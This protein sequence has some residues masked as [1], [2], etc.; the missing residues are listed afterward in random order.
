MGETP[1]HNA[2]RRPH[3]DASTRCWTKRAPTGRQRNSG[4][5]GTKGKSPADL[6]KDNKHPMIVA[7]CDPAF[8]KAE[9]EKLR[10]AFEEATTVHVLST[11]F[12][13]PSEEVVAA[14]Y[15][16]NG[17]KKTKLNKETDWEEVE[18]DTDDEEGKYPG[19]TDPKMAASTT[20]LFLEEGKTEHM[21][22]T[23]PSSPWSPARAWSSTRI[24]P[25]RT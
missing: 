17:I 5:D 10:K 4:A 13:E 12:N 3:R 1:L 20:K 25:T 24:R 14:W 23:S 7:K 9:G 2:A 16:A 21:A 19:C 6:A 11:R 15:K 22:M 8:A 18:C